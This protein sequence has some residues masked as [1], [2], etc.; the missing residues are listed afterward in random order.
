VEI[1]HASIGDLKVA[2]SHNGVH[3]VLHANNGGGRDDIDQVYRVT[4]FDTTEA[5]GAWQLS[6]VDSSAD[7]TGSLLR[8]GL[9][10]NVGDREPL[11]LPTDPDAPETFPG[12][13][14]IAIPD[15]ASAG[16]SSEAGV[17]SDAA[18]I[19]S[20]VVNITHTYRGDLEV[21]L[22]HD[23]QTWVLHNR[24]G[25]SADNLSETYALD[26]APASLGGTW[27]LSVSDNAAADTGTLD[28]WAVVVAP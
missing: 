10:I 18:G 19:A 7:E 24:A 13:G 11:E 20:V 9:N 1:T 8:W 23:G 28:S 22:E 14:G 5:N 16:I 12:E 26:P 27:T 4:A 3:H 2:L 21:A 15:N 17:P 6:V 25:G